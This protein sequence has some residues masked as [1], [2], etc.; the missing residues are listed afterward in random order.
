MEKPTLRTDIYL[1]CSI[2]EDILVINFII[3]LYLQ[4]FSRCTFPNFTFIVCV[5]KF[6]CVVLYCVLGWIFFVDYVSKDMTLLRY[7]T[8]VLETCSVF[9]YIEFC[10]V[11]VTATVHWPYYVQY[12]L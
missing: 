9:Y 7:G 4:I 6:Q 1:Y 3:K 2:Y 10:V 11:F 5:C 12:I 8:T